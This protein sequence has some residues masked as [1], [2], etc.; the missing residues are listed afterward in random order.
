MGT[1]NGND[2]TVWVRVEKAPCPVYDMRC[3]REETMEF[4]WDD[5]GCEIPY[6]VYKDPTMPTP[7]PA[8]KKKKKRG[9][10]SKKGGDTEDPE[11]TE[12][13]SKKKNKKRKAAKPTP[14]KD[15]AEKPTKKPP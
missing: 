5:N 3:S 1:L 10:S 7:S 8:R 12:K 2:N 9:S 4:K 13:P 11:P 15:P 6:C 14:S